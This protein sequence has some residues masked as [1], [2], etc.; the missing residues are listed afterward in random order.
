MSYLSEG[1]VL[2]DHE[3]AELVNKLTAI[4]REFYDHQ[5]LRDRMSRAVVPA[6]KSK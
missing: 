1:R 6:I 2:K 3:I 5:S 4:A